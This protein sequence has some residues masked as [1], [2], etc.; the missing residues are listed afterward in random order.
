MNKKSIIYVNY[1]PYENSGHILDY[2]IE[3]FE[4]VFLFSLAFHPLKGKKSVNRLTIYSKS[5]ITTDENL[6]Y[7]D[8]AEKFSFFL[9]PLRSMLNFLQI[10]YKIFLIRKIYG[11]VDFFFTV[12]AFTATIGRVLKYIGFVRSSIF[13]V[14]DFYPFNHPKVTFRIMRWLYWQFDIFAT[15][16]DRVF[17]LN[18]RL[19]DVRVTY[20]ILSPN[21]PFTTIPIGTGPHLPIK[22]KNNKK[23]KIGFIGVLKKSQGIDM[24]IQSG[25]LLSKHFDDITFEIIGSGPDGEEFRKNAKQYKNVHYNFYGYVSDEEFK[26]ILYNCTIGISPYSP[27]EGTVSKY[28]DPGKPKRYIEFNLPIITTDVIELSKDIV[29]AGAGEVIKYGDTAGFVRALKKIMAN[30]NHYSKSAQL[31]N[32][33]Y[34]Y[35]SIYPQM[36]D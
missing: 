2:L 11:K 25:P 24:L 5:K 23:I 36:F 13:W 20:G 18:H 3:H 6:F 8:I 31:L 4:H 19:R 28:T 27:E 33:K 10:I 9:L 7:L 12:N 16:S 30:Y 21:S 17:Y 1:S 32:K 35:N 29:A 14:W 26:N 22:T 15:F 34:F